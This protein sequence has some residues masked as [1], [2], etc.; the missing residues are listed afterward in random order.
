MTLTVS[1]FA[2]GYKL[3]VMVIDYYVHSC[4][5]LLNN[6]TTSTTSAFRG[7][8]RIYEQGGAQPHPLLS[9]ATPACCVASQ[10]LVSM[11][12]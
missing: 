4:L 6:I 7:I 9:K 11:D 12:M 1:Y 3:I 2:I 8:A 5:D 10:T